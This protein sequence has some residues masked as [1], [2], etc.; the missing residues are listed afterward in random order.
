MSVPV[1]EIDPSELSSNA[2]LLQSA[3]WAGFKA[4]FG[5]EAHAFRPAAGPWS[6]EAIL[7][8][9]RRFGPGLTLAYVPNGPAHPG[10]PAVSLAAALTD[11]GTSFAAALPV[12]P[13]CVRFDLLWEAGSLAPSSSQGGV[14]LR[15]APLDVQPRSTVLIDLNNRPDELLAAMHKKSRYNIGLAERKGVEVRSAGEDELEH[16]YDLYHETA[17]RDRIAIHSLPYYRRLFELARDSIDLSLYLYL[18]D[19][20]GDLLAGIIVAEFGNQATYLYGA[21]SN[22]KRSLMPNHA[23]QWRAILHAREAG[24]AT[25]DLFGVPPADDPAHPMHGL[26]RFKT[27]FGGRLVHRAGSWDVVTRPMSYRAYRIAE[28]ARSF[29]FHR[30]RKAGAR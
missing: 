26:Y 4:E 15:K 2:T 17:L 22:N 6:G 25:Y 23:L 3:V 1:E 27:G 12:T 30:M 18:A 19:H 29:Y 10:E 8:L 20:G 9:F 11:L 16:W 7:A 13:V 28:Q 24:L 14:A 21:S 5:W